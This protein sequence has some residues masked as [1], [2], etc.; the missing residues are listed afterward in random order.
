MITKI[1][2]KIK[3]LSGAKQMLWTV[4]ARPSSLEEQIYQKVV[5]QGDCCFDIGANCGQ[6][7]MFLAHICGPSGKIIAFEPVWPTYKTLC[8]NIQKGAF[9]K[10]III[11]IPYGIAE[12]EKQGLIQV[13]NNNFALG[14]MASRERLARFHK[15]ATITSYE[16][17]FVSI[18]LFIAKT[19][20]DIPNFCKIDV[21]GAELFVLQGASKLLSSKARPII[22]IEIFA[23][24]E[25]TFGYTPW[26]VLSILKRHGYEFYFVCPEGLI[27]HQPSPST[28]FPQEYINGYNVLAY[29]KKT[30]NSRIQNLKNLYAGMGGKILPMSPPPCLNII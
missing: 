19:K 6:V 29:N 22:L 17:Q 8:S 21:E 13:P 24:W 1:K 26:D 20:M 27:S 2:R 25:K 5:Q 12:T 3:K 30:H 16:C 15:N 7:S 14:S 9:Q 11:P 23:P 18:D 10:S 4:L 28:P